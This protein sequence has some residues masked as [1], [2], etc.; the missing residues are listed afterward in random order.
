V[1][2]IERRQASGSKDA[3]RPEFTATVGL[4]PAETGRDRSLEALQRQ[5]AALGA[6]RFDLSLRE[7]S[8]GQTTERTWTPKEIEHALAWL[9]RMNARGHDIHLRPAGEHGLVLVDGL[10]REAIERM[11]RDGFG[12]AATI[13]SSSDRYQTWVKLSGDPLSSEVRRI[14][15]EELGRHYGGHP[16]AAGSYSYG[17]LAGFTHQAPEHTRDGRQP[18]VLAHDCP[19]TVAAKAPA[20]LERIDQALDQKAAQEERQRRLDVLRADEPAA[21]GN[22]SVREYRRQARRLLG[23][24][25]PSGDYRPMDEAIA[26]EMAKSGRYSAAEIER[27]IREGSPNVESRRAGHL[28]QY[29]RRTVERAERTPEVQQHRREL[30][31]LRE[32]RRQLGRGGP[33]LGR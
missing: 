19:G 23:Q 18:Y 21:P 14:A 32:R 16:G 31:L 11:K 17:R 30:E 26:V 33:S 3:S 20:L 29:A 12:P 22:D 5:I 1:G 8:T 10:P 13:E 7:A 28:E 25:L 4:H 15:A 24:Y 6:E 27:S 2:W 9:K